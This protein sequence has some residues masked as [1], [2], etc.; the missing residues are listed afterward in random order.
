VTI[1]EKSVPRLN[2]LADHFRGRARVVMANG[3]TID[4]YVTA[5]DLVIGAVLVPGAAAPKLVSRAQVARMADGSAV[6][7]I[8]IDQGGCFETSRPTTHAEPTFV[9]EGVVHYCVTNMPGAVARTSTFA[10][11]NV[12]LPYVAAIAG[13]GWSAALAS[14]PGFAAG[15]NVHAGKVRHPGVAQAL[16]MPSEPWRP[17]A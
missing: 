14:D 17:P 15:L 4:E 3:E 2:W 6:V 8:A 10:L 13:L 9:A 12:T 5:A 7:D 16:R 11:N 1:L